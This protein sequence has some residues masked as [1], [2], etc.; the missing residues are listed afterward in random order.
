M[1]ALAPPCPSPLSSCDASYRGRSC[2]GD[3]AAARVMMTHFDRHGPGWQT[4]GA[5][6][7]LHEPGSQSLIANG[8]IANGLPLAGRRTLW[9]SASHRSNADLVADRSIWP[10]VPVNGR[11]L[12]RKQARVLRL[13]ERQPQAA[14]PNH[15]GR[16][17]R[18]RGHCYGRSSDECAKT[19]DQC[20][21]RRA[22]PPCLALAVDH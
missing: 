19:A 10:R 14:F 9:V 3:R 5:V 8:L 17:N 4:I 16:G 7:Q 15:P 13:D 11:R 2:R 1:S 12:V 18:R 20:A 21:R 6:A 22:S